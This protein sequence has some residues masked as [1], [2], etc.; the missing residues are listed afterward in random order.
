MAETER[1]AAKRR[2]HDLFD[3]IAERYVA[4]DG[5]DIGPIFGSEGLRIRGK[6]FAF[7]S[8]DGQLIVKVPAERA[9]E[10]VETTPARRMVMREREMKEWLFFEQT[11]AALWPAAVDEA[12][13]Y[14]DRITP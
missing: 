3:P 10:L 1:A 5:V 11:D 2:G 8:F 13:A 4:H 6:I 12:F 9:N 14:V 7:L